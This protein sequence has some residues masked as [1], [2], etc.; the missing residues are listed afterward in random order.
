MTTTPQK[1]LQDVIALGELARLG[2][3]LV[4]LDETYSVRESDGSRVA[5]TTHLRGRRGE[6]GRRDPDEVAATTRLI[7]AA[8][9]FIRQYGQHFAGLEA[10]ISQCR[11][12]FQSVLDDRDTYLIQRDEALAEL[13]QCRADAEQLR[14]ARDSLLR[15]MAT[16]TDTLAAR[17]EAAE[18]ELAKE[19]E[20]SA[21]ISRDCNECANQRN[22]ALAELA[23]CREL[24]SRAWRVLDTDAP[25][26]QIIK[27]IGRY[28]SD[29][30]L[31]RDRQL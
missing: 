7:A 13:S 10:E 14:T 31:Q 17:A 18:A 22:E 20:L 3:L 25:N 27:D 23:R 1:A 15:D 8:V 2:E 12:D 5:L 4:D 28:L 24:L 6:G 29:A 16:V 9:N 30:T 19:R 26:L 21:A 11:A